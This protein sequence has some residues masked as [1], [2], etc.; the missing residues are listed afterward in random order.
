MRPGA[1]SG[2]PADPGFL[3]D[4]IFV[5]TTQLSFNVTDVEGDSFDYTV[6]TSPDIGGSSAVNVSNGHFTVD[7][8][9]LDFSI[10][11]T[12]YVNCTDINGSND[13][14]RE[15]FSF[16]TEPAP[17]GW[18]NNDWQYRKKI[19]IDSDEVDNDLINFPVLISLDNDFVLV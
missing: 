10:T 16:T 8:S 1:T 4:D 6:E 17:P 2:I 14:T 7:I 11:Y 15:S 3:S 18:W 12:W 5:A 9:G 13:W 19:I